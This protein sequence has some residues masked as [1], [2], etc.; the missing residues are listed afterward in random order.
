LS[1]GKDLVTEGFD[2]L[3]LKETKVL[4]EQLWG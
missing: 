2:T 3:V 1:S 4:Q